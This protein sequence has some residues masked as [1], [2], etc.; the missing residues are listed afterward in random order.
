MRLPEQSPVRRLSRTSPKARLDWERCRKTVGSMNFISPLPLWD[1]EKLFNLTLPLP[2]G[3]PKTNSIVE[4][5]EVEFSD[6]RSREPSFSLDIHGFA[7]AK[8]PPAGVDFKDKGAIEAQYL[9][10]IEEFLKKMIGADRVQAFDYT[11]RC[12]CAGII[13]SLR[14]TGFSSVK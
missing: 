6:A 4:P 13:C 5:C 10:Q 7:F 2:P 1:T 9:P 8:L 12:I 3:Q 11:V 14:L